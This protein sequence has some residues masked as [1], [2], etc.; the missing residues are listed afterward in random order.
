MFYCLEGTVNRGRLFKWAQIV[1][2]T[3]AAAIVA[4]WVDN[5]SYDGADSAQ[6]PITIAAA[7]AGVAADH[8]LD[9]TM[10]NIR[11]W[12][13]GGE[14]PL[15]EPTAGGDNSDGAEAMIRPDTHAH[16]RQAI[17]GSER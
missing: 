3:S 11:S 10:S 14:N 17:R 12:S 8:Q 15:C 16:L 6:D 5:S 7:C 9:R 4:I 2:A 13:Q 1:G